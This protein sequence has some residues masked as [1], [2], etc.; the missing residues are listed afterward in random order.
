[1]PSS[2]WSRADG[3][4]GERRT[5]RAIAARRRAT[6]LL[7]GGL[8][9]AAAGCGARTGLDEA[10]RGVAPPAIAPDPAPPDPVRRLVRGYSVC[11][12]YA[13]GRVA[14][15]G[16]FDFGPCPP[17]LLPG[18]DD[19]RDLCVQGPVDGGRDA[20]DRAC[21][22][23]T[24]GR[25]RCQDV[26]TGDH[27]RWFDALTDAVAITCNLGG[28]SFV[29]LRADGTIWSR[30]SQ[31]YSG[32]GHDGG[33]HELA[34][35]P[36]LRDIAGLTEYS[37]GTCAWDRAGAVWCWGDDSRGQLGD[38]AYHDPP[39]I[40]HDPVTPRRVEGL[41]PVTAVDGSPELALLAVDTTGRGW[42]W[43]TMADAVLDPAGTRRDAFPPAVRPTALP[44]GPFAQLATGDTAWLCGLDTMGHVG[45]WGDDSYDQLGQLLHVGERFPTAPLHV[46]LPPDVV[47]LVRADFH[48]TC[49]LTR[50]GTVWCWGSNEFCAY[51]TRNERMGPRPARVVLP[52]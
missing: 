38:G 7:A 50:A 43:G 40:D 5:G 8:A 9:C 17:R 29:A 4:R 32:Q 25:V 42:T 2:R 22:V 1:M 46:A 41:P 28:D 16:T 49:A 30:G 37:I 14:C 20:P 23:T 24:M 47:Q 51:G 34:P 44:F 15:W 36:S 48:A 19:A 21:I 13:S 33:I 18:I 26:E 6:L 27:V 52:P 10:S 3:H 31:W 45:C 39:V 12:I 11:A 35:V